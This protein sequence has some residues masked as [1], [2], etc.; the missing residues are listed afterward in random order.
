MPFFRSDLKDLFRSFFLHETTFLKTKQQFIRSTKIWQNLSDNPQFLS[1]SYVWKAAMT[2]NDL[3]YRVIQIVILY[4]IF[5]F[6]FFNIIMLWYD[7]GICIQ[8]HT[9]T[10]TMIETFPLLVT[11]HLCL[12]R[13]TR[14]KHR[15][16][17]FGI[18]WWPT[19]FFLFSFFFTSNAT[20]L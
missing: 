1:P 15:H 18:C 12:T 17:F 19:M 14:W 3:I 10:Q 2:S 20:S 5:F 16:L 4:R 11:L 8:K 9:L 6:F 13:F 7:R